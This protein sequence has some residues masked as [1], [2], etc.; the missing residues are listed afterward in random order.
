[1]TDPSE[2]GLRIRP[3][4]RALVISPRPAV[5][6]VRFEFPAGR[7]WAL[8]GGGLEP[9][10]DHHSAL[11]REL[12]EEV[13]LHDA[14]IGPHI[15]TREHIFPFIN[16]QWDGQREQIYAVPVVDEFEPAPTMS[17]DELNAEYLFEIR[18]WGLD[19]IRDAVDVTWSPSRLPDLVHEILQN[20]F[21][22]SPIDI[23]P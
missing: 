5:L 21:P 22:R 13:G 20:G 16:G 3:A 1:M 4:T 9:H 11:H 15:W 12:R 10:E 17:W 18:W 2:S 14:D 6:L 23:Q 19:E 8:P 7:R